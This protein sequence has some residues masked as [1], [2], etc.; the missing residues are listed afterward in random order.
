MPG[1]DGIF[2]PFRQEMLLSIIDLFGE[3]FCDDERDGP[4]KTISGRHE[5]V[6]KCHFQLCLSCRPFLLYPVLPSAEYLS[7]SLRH[8]PFERATGNQFRG[9]SEQTYRCGQGAESFLSSHH[10]TDGG[11]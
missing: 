2:C 3:E 8:H 4:E 7:L 11:E 10:V 6:G 9:F 1:S 5:A